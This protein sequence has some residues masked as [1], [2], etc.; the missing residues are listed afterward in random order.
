M[1]NRAPGPISA[2]QPSSVFMQGRFISLASRAGWTGDLLALFAGLFMPLAY[3]PFD[4]YP[5]AVLLPA[6]LFVTW[7]NISPGRAFVRGLLFGAAMFGAGTTWMYISIHY[8]GHVS[9][10]LSI[11]ILALLVMI[12]ALFYAFV[13]YLFARSFQSFA[14]HIRLAVVLP[15][16][17]VLSEWVRGWFMTGFPWL[18][19]GYSQIDSMLG[20]LAPVLGVYGVS[21]AVASSAGLL[22]FAVMKRSWLGGLSI[23]VLWGVAALVGQID[24]TSPAGEPLKVSLIQGNIAQDEKWLVEMRQPT[25]ER[26]SRLTRENWASDL[27]VWPESALPDF[28]YRAL[29][30][31]EP[32]D[33]EAKINDTLL[34]IGVLSVE[35]EPLRYYNSVIGLGVDEGIYHKQHLV[36]FTEYLP[37]KSLLADIVDFMDVPMSD[38]SPGDRDQRLM[39]VE[40]RKIGI[41]ICYEAVF[42]EEL[43][44]NLPAASLL[45]N[46]SNDGWFGKSIGPHQHLQIIRMRA[47]ETGRPL[48]RSTNTGISAIITPYGKVQSVS[49]QFE[50]HVLT[51]SVQPMQGATP[52]ILWGNWMVVML[53]GITLLSTLLLSRRAI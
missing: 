52:Y 11:F 41:S 49:P 3:A 18:N 27:I 13:G 12:M 7:L 9:M 25:I 39:A 16:I 24:W 28:S 37:M 23:V 30:V 10:P 36:P 4:F 31:L 32:L 14:L 50:V 43:I 19:L 21:L 2:P 33:E 26:Y 34:L 44:G 35:M 1:P 29:D 22:L 38:F 47:L 48:L 51:D 8:F 15:A 46:V 40:G 20:G 17:W 45:V 53:A 42:G 5:L 6:L